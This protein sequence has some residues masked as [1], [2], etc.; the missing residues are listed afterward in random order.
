MESQSGDNQRASCQM[1]SDGTPKKPLQDH[2]ICSQTIKLSFLGLWM[3]MGITTKYLR[4]LFQRIEPIQKVKPLPTL[5]IH[6]PF[7]ALIATVLLIFISGRTRRPL[8][9]SPKWPWPMTFSVR[10]YSFAMRWYTKASLRFS[11][12]RRASNW[13]CNVL[14]A[15]IKDYFCFTT[16]TLDS[17]HGPWCVL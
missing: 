16:I 13:P 8:Y 11:S 3:P 10:I 17:F 12:I 14:L 5:Y 15:A 4:I 2:I 7:K 6:L 9:T 1:D